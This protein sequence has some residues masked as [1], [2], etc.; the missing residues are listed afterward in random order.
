MESLDPALIT[1]YPN[2]GMTPAELV[3][4]EELQDLGEAQRDYSKAVSEIKDHL[5]FYLDRVDAII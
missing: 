4:Y 5:A 3:G 1:Q 2:M